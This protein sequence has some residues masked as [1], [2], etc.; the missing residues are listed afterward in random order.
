MSFKEGWLTKQGGFIKSWKKRWFVLT[1]T[2]LIYYTKAGGD[3]KGR[4][5]IIGSTCDLA[6]ECKAQPAFKIVTSSRTFFI[7]GESQIDV[8]L[9]VQ[10]IR[11]IQNGEVGDDGGVKVYMEELA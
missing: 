8:N 9:W 10:A 7:V 4:I 5:P 6:P 2:E 3:E 1:K 11:S